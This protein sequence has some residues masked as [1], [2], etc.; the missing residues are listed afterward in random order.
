MSQSI[1][2]PIE[3]LYGHQSRGN[4]CCS[5]I[6]ECCRAAPQ[7]HSWGHM[8]GQKLMWNG[9][10]LGLLT[11]GLHTDNHSAPPPTVHGGGA[12]MGTRGLWSTWCWP[13]RP[14]VRWLIWKEEGVGGWWV[15]LRHCFGSNHKI[16]LLLSTVSSLSP[17]EAPREANPNP[18][19]AEVH[20]WVWVRKHLQTIHVEW[21]PVQTGGRFIWFFCCSHVLHLYCY[22]AM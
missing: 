3:G 11:I 8:P 10:R 15:S 21:E 19:T 14:D 20:W 4:S 18:A 5:I 13:E 6:M 2:F 22:Y 1:L 16:T 9:T 12:L 17:W 7:M